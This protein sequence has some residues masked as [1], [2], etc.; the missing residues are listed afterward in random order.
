MDLTPMRL[1]DL[2]GMIRDTLN[3]RFDRESFWVLADVSDHKFY[4]QKKNHF[5]DLVEKDDISGEMV[6]R[7]AGAAW[8]DGARSIEI[9]EKDTGQKFTTGIHVLVRVKV[10]FHSTFGIKLVLQEVDSRFTLGELEKKKQETIQRLLTECSD[11]VKMVGDHIVTRNK[12]HVLGLVIQKIAVVSSKQSAGYQDFMHTLSNNSFGYLFN[13]DEYNARVQ[14]EMNAKVLVDQLVNVY[15]SGKNYDVVV[16]IRGGGAET[17][18]LIFNDFYVSRAVAKFP[19][20]I[21]TGIGHQKDQ[22]IADMM[23]HTETK[24]PTKAAEYIIAHNKK[25]EDGLITLQKNVVIK[26]QQIFSQRQ[27]ILTQLNSIVV[28]KSRDYLARYLQEMMQIN[29][30]VTQNS[31]QI[32]HER[33]NEMVSLSS[34]VVARPRV[35]V[36][37]KLHELDQLRSNIS[38]FRNQYL[39]NQQ[40]YLG[41]FVSMIRM[42]SPEQ[43]LKR[44]F[45]LVKKGDQIVTDPDQIKKGDQITVILKHNDILSTVTEKRQ[46]DGFTNNL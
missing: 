23:A 5:F 38:T 16:I 4:P 46:S 13:V 2:T 34:R 21:I 6:A 31:M 37:N 3:Q 14:G 29:R 25:F 15:Q 20:P 28:N 24:T 10:N 22:T 36:A 32:L 33:R 17:D 7:V 8:G 19:V 39:K 1:S 42:A 27:R 12:G 26:A 40:G 43:T 11:Y 45:A 9:F 35:I 41:H 18:F 44:G 30:I